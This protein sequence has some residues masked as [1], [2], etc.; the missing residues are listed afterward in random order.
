MDPRNGAARRGS[1]PRPRSPFGRSHQLHVV[2]NSC[3]VAIPGL[4]DAYART[5]MAPL[6]RP[7]GM[8]RR[9]PWQGLM[10]L[11]LA[12]QSCA[13]GFAQP[14]VPISLT[15]ETCL[16]V[17]DDL[18][19]HL[20]SP[21]PLGKPG[22]AQFRRRKADDGFR[23]RGTRALRINGFEMS[24]TLEGR[25]KTGLAGKNAFVEADFERIQV[26]YT[27]DLLENDRPSVAARN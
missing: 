1:P 27:D 24:L 15:E 10:I 11:I 14:Q 16:V 5:T 8:A 18:S 17:L 23:L 19:R 6:A 2:P 7:K 4:L 26:L 25:T 22:K 21:H 3:R 9:A 12:L 20:A 13:K